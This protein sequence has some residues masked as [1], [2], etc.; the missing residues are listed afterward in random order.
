MSEALTA[1]DSDSTG[2]QRRDR[3]QKKFGGN[4]TSIPVIKHVEIWQFIFCQGSVGTHISRGGKYVSHVVVNLFRFHC[5]RN[6]RNRLTFDYVIAKTKTVQFFSRHRVSA[7]VVPTVW[8]RLSLCIIHVALA[9]VEKGAISNKRCFCPSV[10]L[11]VRP[12]VAY[13]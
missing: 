5:A 1:L 2:E 9:P 3:E 4:K 7:A 11:S 10:R 6:Y 13:M 8:H 12:S